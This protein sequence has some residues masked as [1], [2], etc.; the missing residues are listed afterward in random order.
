MNVTLFSLYL[1]L[2]LSLSLF[3]GVADH[4][5]IDMPATAKDREDSWQEYYQP[6]T[7]ESAHLQR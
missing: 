6:P 5:G 7:E 2:S 1:S 4:Y 3:L